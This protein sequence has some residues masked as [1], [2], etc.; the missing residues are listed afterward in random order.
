MP[1]PRLVVIMV[2]R[3]PTPYDNRRS[4]RREESLGWRELERRALKKETWTVEDRDWS[5]KRGENMNAGG[6]GG[7]ESMI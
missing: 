7:L 3:E 1:T 4:L 5:R 2:K 6:V